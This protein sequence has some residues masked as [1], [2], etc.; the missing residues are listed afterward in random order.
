MLVVGSDWRLPACHHYLL[1]HLK[2]LLLARTV[3]GALLTAYPET[4][5]G[6]LF[7]AYFMGIHTFHCKRLTVFSFLVNINILKSPMQ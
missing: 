2:V 4:S 7:Q 6:T 3:K 5:N 1:W